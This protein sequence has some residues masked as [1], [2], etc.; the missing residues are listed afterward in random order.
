MVRNDNGMFFRYNDGGRHEFYRARGVGDCAT[1]ALAIATDGNY[2]ECYN[3]MKK[4]NRGT[5]RN[6]VSRKAIFEMMKSLG[7]RRINCENRNVRI[8]D[9]VKKEGESYYV[10]IEKHALCIKNH[11]IEDTW[12][13]CKEDS[14]VIA[15]YHIK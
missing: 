14:K 1:R 2:K 10:L 11:V 7:Y 4:F 15:Y 9:I 12:N 8:S 13:S 3:I 6:G 5:P